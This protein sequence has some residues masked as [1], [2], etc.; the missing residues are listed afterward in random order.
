M[1]EY[2]PRHGALRFRLCVLRASSL[3]ET[4]GAHAALGP[5]RQR[6]VRVLQECF[7]PWQGDG[8]TAQRGCVF[9]KVPAC[10]TPLSE[11]GAKQDVLHK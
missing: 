6:R 5:Q 8:S 4:F 2:V 10:V 1:S 9:I 7:S 3:R 11:C